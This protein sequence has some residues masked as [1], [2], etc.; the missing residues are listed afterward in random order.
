MPS[1]QRTWRVAG[2]VVAVAALVYALVIAGQILLGVV[3]AGLVYGTAL[4]VSVTSPDGVVADMGRTRAAVTALVAVGVVAYAVVIA[5][6]LLLGLLAAFLVFLGSWLTAPNGPL[7]RLVRWLLAARE[8][9]RT[10]RDAVT[11]STDDRS[12]RAGDVGA[13]CTG[14]QAPASG[15]VVARGPGARRHLTRP[16][17]WS[18]RTYFS[19]PPVSL[20]TPVLCPSRRRGPTSRRVQAERSQRMKLI[21]KPLD[22]Q[23]AGQGIAA[24]DR[25]AMSDLGVEDGDF[26]TIAGESGTAVVRVRPGRAGERQHG[27]VG[28]DGQTR[29]KIGARLDRL[30]SVDAADVDPATRLSVVL[31]DGLQIRG[32]PPPTS[33]SDSPT[34]R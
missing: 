22:R 26:V 23:S 28:I 5:S 8:D 14:S 32:D 4:L 33:A 19:R 7:A 16:V 1:P 3:A 15:G 11:E 31:P 17:S 18:V 12:T 25:E 24:I 29:Q 13:R 2:A 21:V 10:V 6:T 34:G 27:I 20:S 30:V 9:L